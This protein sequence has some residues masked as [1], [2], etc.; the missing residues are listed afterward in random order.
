[1]PTYMF[2]TSDK[3]FGICA[4]ETGRSLPDNLGPW[5]PVKIKQAKLNSFRTHEQAQRPEDEWPLMKIL[6]SLDDPLYR[7]YMRFVD[8]DL[9]IKMQ[10]DP[11]L[12]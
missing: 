3:Q 12:C 9:S 4:D 6:E 1:M 5:R 11:E 7:E 2:S 8:M 10:K